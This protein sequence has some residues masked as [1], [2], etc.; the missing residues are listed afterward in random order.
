MSNPRD[1]E[2]KNG[3]HLHALFKLKLITIV[4]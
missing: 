1:S 2:Q 3:E 4:W